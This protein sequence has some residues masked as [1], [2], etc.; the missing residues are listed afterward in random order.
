MEKKFEKISKNKIKKNIYF[1]G[2]FFILA[3]KTQ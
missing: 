1:P 3:K 2:F